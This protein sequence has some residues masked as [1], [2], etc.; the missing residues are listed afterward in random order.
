MAGEIEAV[1]QRLGAAL[2]AF[3]VVGLIGAVLIFAVRP[4][5]PALPN[6]RA[7]ALA[8]R[9]S[10]MLNFGTGSVYDG[11]HYVDWQPATRVAPKGLDFGTGS[12][13]D[14]GHYVDWRPATHSSKP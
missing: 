6:A 10:S 13:Y 7:N 14:G 9:G 1:A 5:K 2:M 12:V 4:S 3:G 11:G 8:Q